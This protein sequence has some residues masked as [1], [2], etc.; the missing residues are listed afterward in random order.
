MTQARSV[1]KASFLWSSFHGSR[2]HYASCQG[3]KAIT[4]LASCHTYQLQLSACKKYSKQKYEYIYYS[5]VHSI[6]HSQLAMGGQVE[7]WRCGKNTKVREHM[8]SD[9]GIVIWACTKIKPDSGQS[10]GT[11]TIIWE[12]NKIKSRTIIQNTMGNTINETMEF[13]RDNAGS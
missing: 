1:L 3:S 7:A 11:G 9:L 13:M 12:K 2:K 4:I 6:S 8:I 10:M 5:A